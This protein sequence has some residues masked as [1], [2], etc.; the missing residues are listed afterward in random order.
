LIST[1]SSYDDLD[2]ELEAPRESQG[3]THS[4]CSKAR[5]GWEMSDLDN[6]EAA[7]MAFLGEETWP[8]LWG[9]GSLHDAL[10]PHPC[11]SLDPI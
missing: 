11:A 8:M 4:F 3:I 6:G 1:R 2:L 9:D 5:I 7:E 10:I